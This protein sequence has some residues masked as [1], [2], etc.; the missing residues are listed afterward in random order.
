[1][2][3]DDL[4][5]NILKAWDS[6]QV[7]PNNSE[8]KRI[9]IDRIVLKNIV[10]T[11][12][13]ASLSRE[14]DKGIR[15]S[16][17]LFSKYEFREQLKEYCRQ[18]AFVFENPLPFNEEKIKKLAPAISTEN[19]GMALQV[20]EDGN[21]EIWGVI[22]W[23]ISTNRFNSIPVGIEGFG[24]IRPDSFSITAIGVGNLQISR[25]NSKIGQVLLCV[26]EAAI[27]TPF[28]EKEIGGY[29]LN[30]IS[31]NELY[32]KYGAEY[33]YDYRDALMCLLH[34]IAILSHGAA[35]IIAKENW[36]QKTNKLYEGKYV[37]NRGYD[38]RDTIA[39]EKLLNHELQIRNALKAKPELLERY[40]SKVNITPEDVIES[41]QWCAL[42]LR[43]FYL[44][45]LELIARLS[46]IDGAL[47]L[48]SELKVMI[49]GARL[50]ADKWEREV[51]LNNGERFDVKTYGTR[52]NSMIDFIGASEGNAIG[53]VLS[54][55]GP[56]RGFIKSEK[57]KIVCWP[58]CR[59]SVFMQ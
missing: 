25:G 32:Q 6:H 47:I 46:C 16:L 56:I 45:R 15:F 39:L 43:R 35:I 44:E 49:F 34:R 41:S 2:F 12:F 51:M 20:N 4:F 59:V 28:I 53:F 48:S 18:D 38:M 9:E 17:I 27:P 7:H 40:K 19:G 30:L 11:A 14:E 42:Y 5:L 36:I 21:L 57:D 3:C 29:L 50:T 58:D 10:E 26:F 52:H 31:E 24:T 22:Y 23:G 8:C 33:W 13:R 37:L 55:D 54:Q 1:M